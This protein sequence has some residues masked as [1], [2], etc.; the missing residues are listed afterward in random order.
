YPMTQALTNLEKLGPQ[1]TGPGTQEL[2][3]VK[4]FVQS[5]LNWLPGAEKI[6][7]DP[8][9]IQNFDEAQKYLTNIAGGRAAQF[10]HGTDQA[11][12]TAL[13]ASPNTH[14]SN[15]AA[16]DLTKATIA[17]RRMEQAQVLDADNKGVNPGQ[18][19]KFASNWATNVDP[20]AFMV[21]L[22]T[23]EQLQNLNKTLKNSAE[24]TK[25]NKS[26]QM[27]IDNG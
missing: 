7:G 4:S 19:A 24:R 9:K 23:P 16:V 18:Y 3:T 26:V 10:G 13:T 12:S 6:Y 2:N 25:F 17:L 15:L 20:R 8:A 21:D 1:G 22:M 27:A 5:N 11:L 14:I